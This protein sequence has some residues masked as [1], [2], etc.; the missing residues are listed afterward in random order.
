MSLLDLANIGSFISG[1][2][3]LISLIYLALQIR[4]ASKHT[5]AAM[6][7]A[8]A[9]A[10][11]TYLQPL[12]NDP[13]L[14][15][16]VLRGNA[17]DPSL[18]RIESWRYFYVW[19]AFLSGYEEQFYQHKNG[20]VDDAHHKSFVNVMTWR[21]HEPGFRA[22]WSIVGSSYGPEF[23]AFVN[24]LMASV[25]GRSLP[26]FVDHWKPACEAERAILAAR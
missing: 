7:E 11:N 22:A 15:D 13:V 26:D 10:I 17:G 12:A 3:V 1:V 6:H 23:V 9:A 25:K 14:L 8:R 19:T 4:Q 24:G 2:A 18:D 16:I 5:L 21:C 20:T